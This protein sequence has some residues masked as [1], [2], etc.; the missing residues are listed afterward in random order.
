MSHHLFPKFR[1]QTLAL[2]AFI[3]SGFAIYGFVI[4][5]DTVLLDHEGRQRSEEAAIRN[6]ARRELAKQGILASETEIERWKE[7]TRE[8]L[9]RERSANGSE[10]S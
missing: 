4:G 5:A 7:Q 8:R 1:Y 6:V 10:T 2:K 9:L 3:I